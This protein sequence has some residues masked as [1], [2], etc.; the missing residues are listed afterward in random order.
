MS[1]IKLS[2]ISGSHRKT[3][4]SGKMASYI[5]K[6]ITSQ[7]PFKLQFEPQILDLANAN[8]PFFN[9][10]PTEEE[11]KE[12]QKK[13]HPVS[14]LLDESDAF[15]I[16]S[17][18]WNGMVPAQLKNLFLLINR[19]VYHKPAL[20]VTVSAGPN[21]HYPVAELRMSSYKNSRLL[22][23]PEHLIVRNIQDF[24]DAPNHENF[25]EVRERLIN[26]LHI[27]Y[28][29]ASKLQGI[30]KEI[31]KLPYTEKYPHGL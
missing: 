1:K 6:T 24:N 8:L 25:T 29:Y 20:I 4:E 31:L 15:I 19:E 5:H 18:E 26:D 14:K 10:D 3:S 12:F 27:L 16:V 23:L 28:L 2:I 22:Y 30:G 17:P 21:G 9:D 11:K 13:W 7:D